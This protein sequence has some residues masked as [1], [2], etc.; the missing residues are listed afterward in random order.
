MC[1]ESKGIGSAGDSASIRCN[2]HSIPALLHYASHRRDNVGP[3][4]DRSRAQAAFGGQKLYPRLRSGA[5]A[6]RC[7]AGYA[8][9]YR[10]A[11]KDGQ[12]MPLP[13]PQAAYG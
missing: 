1:S 12:S 9:R 6:G 11:R 8:G 3:I 13:S 2:I 10:T 5:L 4:S 7:L